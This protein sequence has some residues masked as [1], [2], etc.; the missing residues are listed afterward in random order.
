MRLRIK[1][2]DVERGTL[3]VRQGKGDK[4]RVTVLPRGLR[5]E[6]ARQIEVAREVWR[7][8][9]E[10]GIA[11]VYLPGALARKF[12]QAPESLPACGDR[13]ERSWGGESAG[14]SAGGWAQVIFGAPSDAHD[15]IL[16]Q[17]SV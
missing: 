2:V 1:D 17:N 12:R 14:P 10:A 15:G 16:S 3:T 4:D 6:V 8:D 11:G 9:R 7:A 13:G 5:E